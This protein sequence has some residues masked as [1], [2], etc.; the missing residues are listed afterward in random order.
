[1]IFLRKII[2]ILKFMSIFKRGNLLFRAF[3]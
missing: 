3:S 1:L 2:A